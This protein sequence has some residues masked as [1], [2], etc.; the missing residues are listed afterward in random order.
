MSLPIA[1]DRVAEG[2]TGL[3]AAYLGPGILEARA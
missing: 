3:L 2:A 1:V